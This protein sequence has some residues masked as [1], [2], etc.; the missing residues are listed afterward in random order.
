SVRET[1]PR[2]WCGGEKL[3]ERAGR[4]PYLRSPRVPRKAREPR[5]KTEEVARRDPERALS[6][7]EEARQ[8]RPQRR[9]RQRKDLFVREL[10]RIAPGRRALR[11]PA[12]DENHARP[13]A[14]QRECAASAD[15]ASAY[16]HHVVGGR[17]HLGDAPGERI[18]LVDQERAFGGD[19][20]TAANERKDATL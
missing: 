15:D 5:S 3:G 1:Y 9:H 14:A 16:D 12:I 19:V 4:A 17:S 8:L 2:S 6:R 10:P 20:R 18:A 7:E 11:L 13:F